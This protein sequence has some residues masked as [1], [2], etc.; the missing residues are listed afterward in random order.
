MSREPPPV[1]KAQLETQRVSSQVSVCGRKVAQH[2]TKITLGLEIA[3]QW[4]LMHIPSAHLQASNW[5]VLKTFPFHSLHSTTEHFLLS[6]TQLY[7]ANL[8]SA[9]P[10]DRRLLWLL[11]SLAY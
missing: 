11:W 1:K 10:P 8:R 3:N 9:P 5:I 6:P 2:I 7:G 4:F